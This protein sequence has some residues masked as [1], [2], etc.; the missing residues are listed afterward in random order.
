MALLESEDRYRDLFENASDMLQSVAPDGRI[1]VVNKA[2]QDV[3]GYNDDDLANLN[4]FDILHPEHLQTCRKHF[5]KILQDGQ[6]FPCQ[7][8]F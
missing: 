7:T 3:L 5:E 2:W 4:F 8:V 1:L 6:E